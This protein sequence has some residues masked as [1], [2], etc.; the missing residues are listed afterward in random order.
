MSVSRVVEWMASSVR[1]VASAEC[2]SVVALVGVDGVLSKCGTVSTVANSAAVIRPL[3]IVVSPIVR[4]AVKPV[5]AS[6]VAKMAEC[7]RMLTK[8]NGSVEYFVDSESGEHVVVGAGPSMPHVECWFVLYVV[9][10]LVML[11]FGKLLP[12]V[13]LRRKSGS[14]H[15]RVL[16]A[17]VVSVQASCSWKWCSRSLSECPKSR[18]L[19]PD[20]WCPTVKP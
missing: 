9:C 19:R 11:C 7:L 8:A 18:S 13:F 15:S 12:I 2:G 5:K 14:E 16:A 4:M 20:P 1:G 3:H 6:N 10:V 17:P